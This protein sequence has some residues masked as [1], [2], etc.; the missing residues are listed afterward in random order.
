MFGWFMLFQMI[1][2]P[3]LSILLVYYGPFTNTRDMIVTT[4]MTTMTHQYFATWFYDDETIQKFGGDTALTG[5]IIGNFNN[6]NEVLVWVF[7]TED[8]KNNQYRVSIRSR[9]PE[10]NKIAEKHNGGGHRFASGAK[11]TTIEEVMNLIKD[12]KRPLKL[13]KRN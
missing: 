3:M 10:I 1:Y 13:L 12:T 2:V 7:F 8:K 6:I 11:P 5:N 4:A 9:G